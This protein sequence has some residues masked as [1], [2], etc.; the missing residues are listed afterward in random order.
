MIA[1]GLSWFL[2]LDFDNNTKDVATALS[3]IWVADIPS[4]TKDIQYEKRENL[5]SVVI[6]ISYVIPKD[7]INEFVHRSPSLVG[8]TPEVF[9]NQH[10][11]LTTVDYLQK[12]R[13]LN[14]I[15]K[16]VEWSQNHQLMQTR[17]DNHWFQPSVRI[18]GR[19]F[20]IPKKPNGFEG[21]VI[22]DDD[23][24]QNMD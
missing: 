14:D 19:R 22:I 13:E 5:F 17:V 7:A 15:M 21:L 12:E 18:N 20:T 24:V 2:S 4:D 16:L 8:V 10:M 9:D 6:K 1:I 3:L 23:S 11:L